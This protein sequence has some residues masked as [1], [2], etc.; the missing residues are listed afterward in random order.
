VVEPAPEPVPEPTPAPVVEPKPK[1]TPVLDPDEDGPEID[2]DGPINR[3][4]PLAPTEPPEVESQSFGPTKAG[5][6]ARLQRIERL[7]LPLQSRP[8]SRAIYTHLNGRLVERK[9]ELQLS[10]RTPEE[11][12]DLQL[13][14]GLLEAEV[15]QALSPTK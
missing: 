7:I 4:P 15:N 11:L 1:P 14:I 6:E 9:R 13:S 5:L 8:E 12:E 3:L 10:D 2:L